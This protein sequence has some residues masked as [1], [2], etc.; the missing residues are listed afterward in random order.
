L[1]RQFSKYDLQK[2]FLR[3]PSD[4]YAASNMLILGLDA[5]IL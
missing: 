5:L 4:L 1:D 2:T 3:S